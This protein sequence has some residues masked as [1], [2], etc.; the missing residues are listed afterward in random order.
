M[1]GADGPLSTD[2]NLKLVVK[3]NPVFTIIHEEDT[4]YIINS[5][6]TIRIMV[7]FYSVSI[8]CA[9]LCDSDPLTPVGGEY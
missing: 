9:V 1:D 8:S 3:P 5:K 6:T 2:E 7:T 4:E